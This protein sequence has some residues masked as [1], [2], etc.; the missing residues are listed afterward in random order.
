M[1]I[2]DKF[3]F[4]LMALFTVAISNAQGK[5]ASPPAVTTGKINDATITISY[6]SPSVKGRKIWGELVPFDKIWR[7][8]ANEATTIETDKDLTIE[9]SKLPAGK[10]SFF[11]IPSE[12]ESI[13]IFNKVAKQSGTHNYDEKEDQLRVKVQQKIADT[14]TESLTYIINKN[15]IVLS[16]EKWKIPF[17]VK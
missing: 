17:S 5:P 10:Y 13:L 6:S 7:A 14:N 15:S 9:G 8:G 12:K 2:Q 11:V 3:L 4:L 1:K 16:W